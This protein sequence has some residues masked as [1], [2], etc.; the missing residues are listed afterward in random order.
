M[1]QTGKG[2]LL[3]RLC[4]DSSLSRELHKKF[5]N[6]VLIINTNYEK[7]AWSTS[8]FLRSIYGRY[9][10]NIVIISEKDIP[11]IGVEGALACGDDGCLWLRERRCVSSPGSTAAS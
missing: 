8:H 4:R 10:D 1:L 9:F 11:E 5:H 7:V 2:A 3:H 6:T